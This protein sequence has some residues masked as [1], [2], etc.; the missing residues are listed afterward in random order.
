ML[1]DEP[2]P[3]SELGDR[4]GDLSDSKRTTNGTRKAKFVAA[5]GQLIKAEKQA[6]PLAPRRLA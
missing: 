5:R 3:L 4:L 2:I 1:K 6:V